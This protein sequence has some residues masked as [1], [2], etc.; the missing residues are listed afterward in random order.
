M[1]VFTTTARFTTWNIRQN[2]SQSTG[3]PVHQNLEI[4]WHV[5]KPCEILTWKKKKNFLS[6]ERCVTSKK[7]LLKRLLKNWQQELDWKTTT[8]EPMIIITLVS[9]VISRLVKTLVRNSWVI[10]RL[11]K[12]LVRNSWVISRLVNSCQ[13]LLGNL[14]T[15]ENWLDSSL[16]LHCFFTILAD[17][18]SLKGIT[19]RV[20]FSVVALDRKEDW[21]ATLEF[22][23]VLTLESTRCWETSV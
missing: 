14:A 7:R 3:W 13:E 11:V 12:T 2:A 20:V 5:E 18:W 22:R 21:S 9:W 16:E 4:K 10:S 6:G 8:A 23:K 19:T 17:S 1:S 15:R